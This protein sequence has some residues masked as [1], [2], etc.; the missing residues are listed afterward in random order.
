MKNQLNSMQSIVSSLSDYLKDYMQRIINDGLLVREYSKKVLTK[1]PYYYNANKETNP[2]PFL[3]A[4][5]PEKDAIINKHPL[6]S[7]G[8][9]SWF[10]DEKTTNI[11]QVTD[12]RTI[13]NYNFAKNL[14]V[15]VR[16]IVRNAY[17]LLL[18]EGKSNYV[19]ITHSFDYDGFLYIF[20]CPTS[21]FMFNFSSVSF[22]KTCLDSKNSTRNILCADYYILAKQMAE[23]QRKLIT[24]SPPYPLNNSAQSVY[25]E[26]STLAL[27]ICQAILNE[28]TKKLTLLTCITA[29]VTDLVN[30]LDNSSA[31][32]IGELTILDYSPNSIGDVIYRGG[33]GLNLTGYFAN[34]NRSSLL[35]WE[36]GVNIL[37]NMDK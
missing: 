28:T 17:R 6:K 18:Y 12:P 4:G 15:V 33:N 36:F 30:H 21:S 32:Q 35:Q 37:S 19:L 20:P 25:N 8:Y 29:N 16:P 22:N 1:D 10:L 7:L 23:E 24:F 5:T 2:I 3:L 34:K 27:R 14:E 11:S 13:E 26:N 9:F 31:I